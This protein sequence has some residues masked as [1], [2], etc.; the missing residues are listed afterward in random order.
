MGALPLCQL[1]SDCHALASHVR[2]ACDCEDVIVVVFVIVVAVVVFD[3]VVA[4]AV[5]VLLLYHLTD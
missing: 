3:I 1:Y 4:V 2:F 5:V